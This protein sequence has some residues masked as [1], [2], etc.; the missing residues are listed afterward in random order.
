MRA[1]GRAVYLGYIIFS[2]KVYLDSFIFI[3]IYFV[4]YL[5]YFLVLFRL[6]SLSLFS[7][8]NILS[9]IPFPL[10]LFLFRLP[11]F[12][13]PTHKLQSVVY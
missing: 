3:R 1:F 6:T 5:N 11:L 13:P 9:I 4:S 10:P 7:Y 12:L 8:F 2:R